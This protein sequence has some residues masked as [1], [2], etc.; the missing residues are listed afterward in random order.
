MGTRRLLMALTCLAFGSGR[1]QAADLTKVDRTIAKEPAYQAKPKYCLLVLGP[2]AQT[3]VWLVQDGSTLYIDRN[4]NG[5]LTEPGEKVPWTGKDLRAGEITGPD[6]K[7]KLQVSLRKYA[8]SVRI[9]VIESQ[10]KRYMVG[11][12]DSDPLAFAA[13]ASEAPV[14]HLGGFPSL[15]LSY[16]WSGADSIVLRVRLGTPGLGKGSF[17]ARVLPPFTPVA[18]IEFAGK[19]RQA[20]PVVTKVTLDSW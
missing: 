18:A 16:Y 3:R 5:D 8:N 6:S 14:A 13:R 12:P 4:G 9:T 11:D 15:E 17:A 10:A 19:H 20:P 2:A 1:A 7:S